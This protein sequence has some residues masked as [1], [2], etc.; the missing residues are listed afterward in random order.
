MTA[1]AKQWTPHLRPAIAS[2]FSCI[3]VLVLLHT[4]SAIAGSPHTIAIDGSNDFAADEDVPGTSGS[5]WYF[6]WDA[7]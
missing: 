4:P 5:T 6:T 3:C 1:Q 7:N 2:V